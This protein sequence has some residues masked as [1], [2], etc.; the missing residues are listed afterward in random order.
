MPRHETGAVLGVNPL[1]VTWTVLPS[2]IASSSG[3][4]SSRRE[5]RVLGLASL[6]H[7]DRATISLGVLVTLLLHREQ[8]V[9]SAGGRLPR[10]RRPLTAA[11]CAVRTTVALTAD[12]E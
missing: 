12:S 1:V 6:F 3:S 9:S 7:R 8:G 2:A 4:S 5:G 11:V 10:L